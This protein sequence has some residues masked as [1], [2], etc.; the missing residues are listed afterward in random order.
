MNV[1]SIKLLFILA[2]EAKRSNWL[3]ILS[4]VLC[5]FDIIL[6][7]DKKFPEHIFERTSR[8]VFFYS[9]IMKFLAF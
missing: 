9:A 3:L 7:T 1:G 4:I 5:W 2:N 6:R 8:A